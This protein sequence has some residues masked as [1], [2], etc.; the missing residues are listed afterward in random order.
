MWACGAPKAHAWGWLVCI[1]RRK[2]LG[3]VVGAEALYRVPEEGF[4]CR[5]RHGGLWAASLGLAGVRVRISS[6]VCSLCTPSH[7]PAPRAHFIQRRS[8]RKAGAD[9]QARWAGALGGEGSQPE[10]LEWREEDEDMGRRW[11]AWRLLGEQE[12]WWRGLGA[13]DA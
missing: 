8:S 6:N 7:L 2:G 3:G 4:P 11:R 12:R 10:V 5:L 9:H 13:E 1:N